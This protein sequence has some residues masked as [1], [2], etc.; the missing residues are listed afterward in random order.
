MKN[1]KNKD[2]KNNNNISI[3]LLYEMSDFTIFVSHI[4]IAF[5]FPEFFE[6]KIA[7]IIVII[8][9]S[10]F[11]FVIFKAMIFTLFNIHPYLHIY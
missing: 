3:K 6:H 8:F 2:S 11:S 5:F 9:C 10:I 4:Y 1:N 7:S